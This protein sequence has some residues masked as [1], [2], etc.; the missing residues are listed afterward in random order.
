MVIGSSGT[1]TNYKW[2]I[3]KYTNCASK[4]PKSTHTERLK[5]G[6]LGLQVK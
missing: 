2:K 6:K 3:L 4:S 1:F 5:L